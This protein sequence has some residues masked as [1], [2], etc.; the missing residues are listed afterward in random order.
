MGKSWRP[1]AII[2]FLC[3]VPFPCFCMCLASA[4]P[5]L[6]CG[7]LFFGAM[8][9]SDTDIKSDVGWK[10]KKFSWEGAWQECCALLTCRGCGA[11]C[12]GPIACKTPSLFGNTNGDLSIET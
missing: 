12:C 5:G 4:G 3:C 6:T 10:H 8:A 7:G 9:L 2:V 1:F 11:Y